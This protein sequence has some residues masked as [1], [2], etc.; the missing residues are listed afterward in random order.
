[1]RDILNILKARD[2]GR[3][4]VLLLWPRMVSYTKDG[5]AGAYE[6]SFL[7][8]KHVSQLSSFFFKQQRILSFWVL[9]MARL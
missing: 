1:M 5:L 7:T 9:L 3:A 4:Q 6:D 2:E 8:A